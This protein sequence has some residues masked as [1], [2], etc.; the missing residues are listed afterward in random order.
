MATYNGAAFL[1]E[2]LRSIGSQTVLPC[3]LVI[4]DDLS[5]DDTIPIAENFA[6]SAPFPVRI[7]RNQSNLGFVRNFRASASRC[8]GDLIAFCDQDDW[9][10]PMRI[11]R[12]LPRFES[13]DVLLLYHNARTVDKARRKIGMLYEPENERRALDVAP[14]APWHWC[15]GLLQVFRSS[16]RAFDELWEGAV[17]HVGSG[18]LAHD[19][20]YF[21]LAQALGRVEFLEECLVDY[22]QH[23]TNAF[24]AWQIRTFGNG[25][26]KRMAH[27]ASQD[28]RLARAAQSRAHIS[29]ALSERLPEQAEHL[30][31]IANKYNR[32]AESYLRRARSYT[33]PTPTQRLA[34]FTTALAAG[35]YSEW[36]WGFDKR[37][38]VRDF[39][40][41]VLL[42]SS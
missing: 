21:F 36:P 25:L 20:W 33:L 4:Q 37:S 34:N 29:S 28:V 30:L 15:N 23:E 31:L 9:W 16:L 41:G 3:E 2:Q 14:F 35:D 8:V 24:G 6:R 22:R 32:L 27:D 12:C 38:I 17:S 11:E 1:E 5:S 18:M 13:S 40:A 42:A 10:E 19:R 7:I 39:C 26:L